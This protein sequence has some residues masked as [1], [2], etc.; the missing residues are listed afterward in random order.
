M[1]LTSRRRYTGPSAE[2]IDLVAIR[3][4]GRCEFPGCGQRAQDPH[5]RFERGSGGAGPKGPAWIN[6]VPNILAACRHHNDWCSNQQPTEAWQMGWIV[7]HPD[8]P[9]LVPALTAHDDLPVFLNEDGSISLLYGQGTDDP[10]W[11]VT[12]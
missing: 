10:T 5:H 1:M 9:F 3:S 7:R 12:M 11:P 8:V 4:G 2:V 6:E